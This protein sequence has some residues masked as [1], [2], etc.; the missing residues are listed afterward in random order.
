M[1]KTYSVFANKIVDQDSVV[2]QKSL[3][4]AHQYYTAKRKYEDA[5][6]ITILL[7]ENLDKD[8]SFEFTSR[9]KTKREESFERE[10]RQLNLMQI[11]GL[12]ERK[13]SRPDFYQWLGGSSRHNNMIPDNSP[14]NIEF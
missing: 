13:V 9:L 3:V 10:Q 4:I 8:N 2:I 1:K 7:S 14:P 6:N 12:T 5:L 11:H